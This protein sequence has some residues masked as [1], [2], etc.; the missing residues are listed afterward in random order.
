MLIEHEIKKLQLEN[1]HVPFD[2]WY[3]SL[4]DK[5]V[6]AAV[7]VRLARIRLGNFGNCRPVGEGVHELKID[8]G[9]GWRIYYAEYAGRLVLLLGGGDKST[10]QRDISAA[11][12]LWKQWKESKTK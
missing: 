1:G 8:L 12:K 9:P 11:I 2:E 3:N 4:L 10:Q 7:N 5:K 6:R